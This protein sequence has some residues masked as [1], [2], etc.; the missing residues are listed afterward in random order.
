MQETPRHQ[1][2]TSEGS[3]GFL[4]AR[5]RDV[6]TMLY[7]GYWI[8]RSQRTLMCSVANS[9]CIKTQK[10]DIWGSVPG[11]PSE[12]TRGP[13]WDDSDGSLH[14]VLGPNCFDWH[15][16]AIIPPPSPMHFPFSSL[17]LLF[18]YFDSS[19]EKKVL[20]QTRLPSKR[21]V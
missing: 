18:H 16:Y 14:L 11:V 3:P 2:R 13:S 4:D 17:F 8:C 19:T 10:D 6:A 15:L 21:L 20:W 1:T 5:P 9:L 7:Q 12:N